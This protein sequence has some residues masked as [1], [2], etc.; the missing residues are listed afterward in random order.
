MAAE[1]RG[2]GLLW[3]AAAPC[4]GRYGCGTTGRRC[5][6]A[7]VDVSRPGRAPGRYAGGV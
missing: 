2:N 1:P 3:A 7:I 5:G 6:S 4:T